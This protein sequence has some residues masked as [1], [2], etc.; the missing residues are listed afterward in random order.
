MSE[1]VTA[2]IILNSVTYHYCYGTMD[3]MGRCN[4]CGYRIEDS[5]GQCNRLIPDPE[6]PA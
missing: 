6:R 2:T 4:R 5:G 3:C 1:I